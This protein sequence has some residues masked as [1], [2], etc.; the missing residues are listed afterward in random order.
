[1]GKHEYRTLQGR[2]GLYDDDVRELTLDQLLERARPRLTIRE[3][4]ALDAALRERKGLLPPK[5]DL[6]QLF[7]HRGKGMGIFDND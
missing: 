5:N 7:I 3:L 2:A 1:M 6:Q 4:N